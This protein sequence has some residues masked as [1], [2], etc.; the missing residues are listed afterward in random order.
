M[1]EEEV[2]RSRCPC[3][4]IFRPSS[5]LILQEGVQKN[6]R[7]LLSRVSIFAYLHIPRH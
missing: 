3:V 7:A 4:S 1:E 5:L 2:A 6:Q